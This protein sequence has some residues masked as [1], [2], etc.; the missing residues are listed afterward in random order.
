MFSHV[1][2]KLEEKLSDLGFITESEGQG[3]HQPEVHEILLLN[4]ELLLIEDLRHELKG[5][6]GV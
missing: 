3:L 2:P 4:L 5:R 6:E 1:Y